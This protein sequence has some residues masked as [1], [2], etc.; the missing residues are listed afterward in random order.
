MNF[1][2]LLLYQWANAM[3]VAVMAMVARQILAPHDF[4]L[5]GA[6]LVA[7][8]GNAVVPRKHRQHGSS[9]QPRCRQ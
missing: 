6:P 7:L 4:W 8:M 5:M 2:E 1:A 9:G 3:P